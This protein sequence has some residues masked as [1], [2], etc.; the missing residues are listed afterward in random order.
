MIELVEGREKYPELCIPMAMVPATISNNVPG[1]D[2]S[3]GCD[4][5]LNEITSVS[6]V[7]IFKFYILFLIS[8]LI[9]LLAWRNR[10]GIKKLEISGC[11]LFYITLAMC[12]EGAQFF[13]F[14]L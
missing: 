12:W 14:S 13:L 9:S 11:I 5:A 2:F 7:C 8:I 4:T 3:L 6:Y 10:K 1:T